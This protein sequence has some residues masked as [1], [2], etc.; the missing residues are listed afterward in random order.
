M[1]LAGVREN[2]K[3]E[4][5]ALKIGNEVECRNCKEYTPVRDDDPTTRLETDLV[6]VMVPA[7]TKEGELAATT[8]VVWDWTIPC[9]HCGKEMSALQALPPAAREVLEKL[10]A[11]KGFPSGVPCP[12][13]GKGLASERALLC[14]ACGFKWF[15]CPSCDAP[16]ESGRRTCSSCGSRL[17][18]LVPTEG[19]SN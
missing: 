17:E 16:W 12:R 9:P 7:P 14:V 2:P 15:R 1:F 19:E 5:P 11:E 10:K 8:G 4:I 6:Q 13:C 18:D 3:T